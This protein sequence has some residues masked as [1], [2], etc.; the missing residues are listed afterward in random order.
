MD[1]DQPCPCQERAGSERRSRSSHCGSTV[2]NPTS[3]QEDAGSIPGLNGWNWGSIVAVSCGVGHRQGSDP[4][5][6]WCRPVAAALIQ[7]LAW[8]PPCTVGAALKRRNNS[9]GGLTQCCWIPGSWGLSFRSNLCIWLQA[10]CFSGSIHFSQALPVP[11]L[12]FSSAHRSMANLS[13]LFG[14]VSSS[15]TGGSGRRDQPSTSLVC[16]GNRVLAGW[17]A[18]RL[19]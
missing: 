11:T 12:I 14:Q 15:V 2:M 19:L 18:E 5:W 1:C 7:L 10:T 6:L 13:V 8:E 4:V 3:T 9:A 17:G 16:C